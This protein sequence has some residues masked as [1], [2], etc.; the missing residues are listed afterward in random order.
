MSPAP[1]MPVHA[2]SRSP[3]FRGAFTL[4][5]VLI[6]VVIIGLAAAL[7]VP[8]LLQ[9]GS[10]TVQAGTRMVVS[11]LLYAQNE[12]VARAAEHKVIFEIEQNR[13]RLVDGA[14]TPLTVGGTPGPYVIDFDSDARFQGVRIHSADFGGE[15][16]VAFDELGGP[17]VGG[18]V[19]LES[20][21]HRYRVHVAAFTGRIRVEPVEEGG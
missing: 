11:D 9:S 15:T 5:E 4:V 14:D 19:D 10:L 6:V 1:I 17:N 13:Y 21:D 8:Q 20:G 3:A 2:D 16:W 7:V 18:T 12:A